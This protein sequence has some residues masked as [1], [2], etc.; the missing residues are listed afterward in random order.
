MAVGGDSGFGWAQ[1]IRDAWAKSV[2]AIVE[3]GRLLC[4]A[5]AALPHG[6]WG[7]L[8]LGPRPRM[9]APLPF[10]Q[11][12]AERLMA[13]ARHPVLAN[14]DNF[15][16]LPA[17]WPTLHTL[18]HLPAPTLQVAL[19]SGA[20]HATMTGDAAKALR[21]RFADHS[22]DGTPAWSLAE[23]ERRLQRAIDAELRRCQG[24]ERAVTE[25]V[26]RL[27]FRL[28]RQWGDRKQAAL[29]DLDLGDVV[30]RF[31]AEKVEDLLP[32]VNEVDRALSLGG[33]QPCVRGWRG[34]TS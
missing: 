14:P 30:A 13:I 9:P 2:A 8:F 11:D 25:M 19:A 22:G 24:Q 33:G 32:P 17:A 7:C 16:N 1:K 3:V 28:E 31:P 15:R 21:A 26:G 5:K 18:S 27:W 10:S 4:E 20:V 34:R 12:V 6:E 29:D 23:A